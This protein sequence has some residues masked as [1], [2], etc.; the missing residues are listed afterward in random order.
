MPSE[1]LSG[2]GLYLLAMYYVYIIQS[3]V[4]QQYYVGY[5][6]DLRRRLSD[7]NAGHSP[8]T[9]K[10]MPWKL[11]TFLGFTSKANALHFEKYLKS[12]SGIAFAKRHLR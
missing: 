9:K 8:H 11:I 2:G 4:N 7:H 1:A 5:T 12:G 3:Q 6:T 10:Y